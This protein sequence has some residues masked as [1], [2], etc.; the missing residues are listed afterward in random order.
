MILY[1]SRP[2]DCEEP[3]YTNMFTGQSHL[4]AASGVTIRGARW[5]AMAYRLEDSQSRQPGFKSHCGR[6]EPLA[7]LINPRCHSLF[8]C[9]NEYLAIQTMVEMWK[10]SL[11]AIA[12]WLNA[13]QIRWDGIGMNRSARG[14][15]VKRFERPYICCLF[16]KVVVS[17]IA[18]KTAD[19]LSLQRMN[20]P[21]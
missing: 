18:S 12:A 5:G 7:S 20:S 14:W 15:S 10:N 9:I 2:C 21:G 6:F 17:L 4:F 16:W 11:H 8:S 1:H 19:E 13:S 3:T